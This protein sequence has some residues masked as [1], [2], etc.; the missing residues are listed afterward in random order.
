MSKGSDLHGTIKRM[1]YWLPMTFDRKYTEPFP[2][3]SEVIQKSGYKDAYQFNLN[4]K[5]PTG[6]SG[7]KLG[8]V[9]YKSG[10]GTAV[11]L[12][13]STKYQQCHWDFVT[14]RDTDLEWYTDNTLSGLNRKKK[15]M[16]LL[17]GVEDDAHASVLFES[18]NPQTCEQNT[19]DWFLDQ[20]LSGTSSTIAS[21]VLA[22]APLVDRS[23]EEHV[24]ESFKTVLMYSGH[25]TNILGRSVVEE[26]EDIDEEGEDEMESAKKLEP[27]N[28]VQSL[29]DPAMDVDTEFKD[30]LPEMSIGAL[31]WM[32]ALIKRKEHKILG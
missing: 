12:A 9:A 16:H 13:I 32:V 14:L 27:T 10:T 5:G 31:L 18:V 7:R 25:D 1:D 15:A 2:A 21:L 20:Q 6:K 23:E 8:C 26:E 24:F 3:K 19:A 29:Q 30:A 17:A 28:W 22:V 4:W 11:A